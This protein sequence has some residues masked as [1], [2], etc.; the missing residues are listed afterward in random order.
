MIKFL[1]IPISRPLIPHI[2]LRLLTL[3][4]KVP[5]ELSFGLVLTA[6]LAASKAVG[7]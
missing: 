6:G 3:I 2:P 1:S 5:G 7:D 4:A